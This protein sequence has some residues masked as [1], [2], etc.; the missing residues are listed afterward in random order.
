MQPLQ[1]ISNEDNSRNVAL[2]SQR[3]LDDMLTCVLESILNGKP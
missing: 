1:L 2:A 3:I